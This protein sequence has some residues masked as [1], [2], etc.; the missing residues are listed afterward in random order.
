MNDCPLCQSSK[1]GYYSRDKFREFFFCPDCGLIF[2]PRSQL[3]DQ[4]QEKTRYQSH[5]N[6]EDDDFYRQYLQQIATAVGEQLTV[7]QTGLDFGCGRTSLLAQLFKQQGHECDSYDVYFCPNEGIWQKK[8]RFIILSEVIEHLRH[9]LEDMQ[10]VRELLARGGSLFIKTKLHPQD[11]MSF[12]NWF[13][14]RDI[15]HVQFFNPTSFEYLAATLGLSSPQQVGADLF[16]FKE[17]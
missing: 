13:Y 9:P 15:T 4:I 6:A 16:Q 3:I 5:Q 8:Y 11:K 7:A 12:D 17:S 2:V 10:R 1:T 14:K